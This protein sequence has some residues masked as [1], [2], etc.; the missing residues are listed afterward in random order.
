MAYHGF[1]FQ[2]ALYAKLN[3]SSLTNLVTGI[4]DSVPEDATLPVVIIGSQT[5]TDDGTKDLDGRSY[6]FKR[7]VT[8][9]WSSRKR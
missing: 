7:T 5:T 8:I 1:E 9:L 6:I 4:F 3:V 2:E